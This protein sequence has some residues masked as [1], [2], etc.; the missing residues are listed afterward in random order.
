VGGAVTQHLVGLV[1]VAEHPVVLARTPGQPADEG[2]S[3]LGDVG[4]VAPGLIALG[5]F[6]RAGRP[7]A[8]LGGR[9]PNTQMR[10]SMMAGEA[11]RRTP[12]GAAPPTIFLTTP[13][14]AAAGP[15][16]PVIP[17]DQPSI[18]LAAPIRLP[19]GGLG[20]IAV[21]E[22]DRGWLQERLQ[23]GIADARL[24]TLLVDE[25]GRVVV[26]AGLPIA[27]SDTLAGHPS[28]L[29]LRDA[30]T[31]RGSLRFTY[32]GG[33]YLAGYARVPDTTWAVIVEQP[34]SSALASVWAGR[35]LTFG[36]LLAAFIVAAII[37]A[38]L[39][40]W[41]AAPLA[42]LARA[43]QMLATGAQNSVIPGSRI[44]EVR[45]VA[46]AFAQMQ[47]RL[48]ARTAERERAEARLRILAHASGELTRSL[49]ESA[50]VHALGTIV[51]AQMADWCVVDLV[52][53][54]GQLR[55][56]LVLHGDVG[57]QALARTLTEPCRSLGDGAPHP[58]LS[59]E[60]V[61][62]PLVTPRQIAALAHTPEQ[63]RMMEWLGMRSLVGV[64]LRVRDK[65]LGALFCIYGRGQRRYDAD[66][67]T[68]A[69]DLALRAALAIENAHLYTA[70]RTARSEAEAA[71]G[72]REE[73]LAIAAHE[74]KTPITSL[75]G[76]AELGVRAF[77]G[78]GSI[79]QAFARRTLETIDRQSAR[80]SALV[81]NLLEVARGT[82][83]HRDTLAPR[84]INLVELVRGVIEVA[85]VRA[86]QHSLTIEAPDAV[87]VVADPLRIEQ[88][89]TN[90]VD[91]AAKFSPLGT[92][93]DVS[94]RA[95]GDTAEVVVRDHG[96]GIPRE[97]RHRIFDRF[98]QGH[99]G[100]QPSGMG[101]GLYISQEIVRRHGGTLRAELPEDGGTRM[102]MTLPRAMPEAR[103]PKPS[104][105]GSQRLG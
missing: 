74:L 5:S 39:A 54:D 76:F 9:A 80:L 103:V 88:V 85:R 66:D 21:G 72:V 60:P 44:H 29:A 36:V 75:R 11:L 82:T 13:A 50:I 48:S 67:L 90:L 62:L 15:G 84:P 34:T 65:T 58:A 27:G 26:A 3:L 87:E 57:R 33:E 86:D 92:L 6:D 63:C 8:V 40:A 98:F 18:A 89:I 68:L 70:E 35:E 96:P 42:L 14:V 16:A 52:D 99:V 4:D 17:G 104:T 7:I 12:S 69:Q 2:S 55:R 1:L 41:L 43:A 71:V 24:T 95:E 94:V 46:R 53:E 56:A 30:A 23:R 49:D 28:F 10:L 38:L 101:L 100:E 91:N 32:R 79:D 83:T 97:H 19:G 51:V 64:P 102:V 81:A 25:D 31:L 59:G 61:L 22:L 93:I 45:T 105:P 78:N 20:G 77:D 37:G 47:A 73:F